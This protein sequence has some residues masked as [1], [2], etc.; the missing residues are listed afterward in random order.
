MQEYENKSMMCIKCPAKL[1]SAVG[2]SD[3]SQCI[4]STQS[5]SVDNSLE[6]SF[7]FRGW[8]R[9]HGLK[10]DAG[11]FSDKTSINVEIVKDL[12]I[13]PRSLDLE[14]TDILKF[15]VT[16]SDKFQKP[17]TMTMAYTV[18][19]AGTVP[20]FQTFDP[21]GRVWVELKAPVQVD[22]ISKTVQGKVPHF[23]FWRLSW[24]A[25]TANVDQNKKSENTRKSDAFIEILDV[26]LLFVLFVTMS[27][28]SI[29]MIQRQEQKNKYS[30]NPA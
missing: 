12:S 5:V 27:L 15:D 3:I 18:Q 6:T 17:I 20:V 1:I 2:S 28:I 13:F 22:T 16:G 29:R 4:Q 11:T 9:L 30:R 21:V 19:P 14:K 10:I 8:P 25:Q 26:F 23:S 7:S 24:T